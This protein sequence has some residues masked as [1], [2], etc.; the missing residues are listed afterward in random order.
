MGYKLLWQVKE[1]HCDLDMKSEITE[2]KNLDC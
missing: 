1:R 2:H